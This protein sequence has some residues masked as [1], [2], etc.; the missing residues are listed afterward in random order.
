LTVDRCECTAHH[1]PRRVV[2]TGGPGAGKTALIE[3]VREH[4]CHHVVALPEAA[5]IVFGG[6]F[7]RRPTP[8]ARRAAQRA[9]YHVQSELE[10][11]VIDE[12]A[13][14]LI[15]CD[16]GTLDGLAYW[17]GRP[18]S[19]FRQ[20]G[21]TAAT[22]CGR[23]DLVLHL[24]VPGGNRGDNHVNPLRIGPARDAAEID[25]AIADAW[26]GHPL[27]IEIPAAADFHDKVIDALARLREALPRCCRGEP[28]AASAPALS[29][30]G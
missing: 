17:P 30:P 23:Y 6:G 15:L 14:G 28:R 20:L 21:T 8:A 5:G 26:R 27:V 4:L 22:E 9:I 24:R 1:A 2:V 12:P 19:F 7:P 16:R 29:S 11:M 18:D 25:A 13:A 3:R 10:M